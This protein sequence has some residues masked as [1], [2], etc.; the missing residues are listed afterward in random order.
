MIKVLVISAIWKRP[1]V[2]RIF[3]LQLKELQREVEAKCEIKVLI[4]GSE[5]AESRAL[6]TDAGF[7]Y[8][9]HANA[10]LGDKWNMAVHYSSTMVWDYLLMLGSDDLLSVS[11]FA[12]Y[13]EHAK[14]GADFI[15]LHDIYV[16]NLKTK[17]VKWWGGYRNHRMGEAA[18]AGRML[19]R[20][21]V[22]QMGFQLFKPGRK[23]GLDKTL[24][25][26]LDNLKFEKVILKGRGNDCI[27]VDV[28]SAVNMVEWER[29]TGIERPNA[30]VMTKYFSGKV[31]N[32][33]YAA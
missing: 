8:I 6:V 29:I 32:K 30:Q 16:F 5:G 11:A 20:A 1:E 3:F 21:L 2:T 14:A 17:A 9:E 27:L 24:T 22:E 18:G 12:K 13:L 23:K 28:K 26:K 19:R 31:L 25:A 10:P 33:L 4:V 15:G 7:E